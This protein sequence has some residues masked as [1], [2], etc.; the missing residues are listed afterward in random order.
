[1]FK[2]RSARSGFTLP[3]VLVTVAIVAVLAAI[4]VPAVTQQLGKGDSAQFTRNVGALQTGATSYVTDVRRFPRYL[5]QLVTAPAAGDSATFPLGVLSTAEA[6][7]WRGPYVQTEITGASGF[8]V[9]LGM[10]ASDTLLADATNNYLTLRLKG[11]SSAVNRADTELDGGSGASAGNLRWVAG[12]T[13]GD[14]A[15]YRLLVA[16]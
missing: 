10:A 4:V 6:A 12:A 16:R 14:S 3:E 1:M 11:D 9:G 7:R 8:V 5:S 2:R 13:R 15:R